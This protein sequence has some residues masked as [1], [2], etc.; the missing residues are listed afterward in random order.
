M[1]L[2]TDSGMG[3]IFEVRFAIVCSIKE[4]SCGFQ[5]AWSEQSYQYSTTA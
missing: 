3:E 1:V 2:I 5:Y 4:E